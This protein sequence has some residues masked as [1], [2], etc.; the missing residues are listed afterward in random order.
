MSASA[1]ASSTEKEKRSSW[2]LAVLAR[3]LQMAVKSR[4][5]ET[6]GKKIRYDSIIFCLNC[7]A[8][9]VESGASTEALSELT[10]DGRNGSKTGSPPFLTWLTRWL[11]EETRSFRD[12]VRESSFGASAGKHAER[13]LEKNEDERLVTAGN[14]FV[15]L[16]CVMIHSTCTDAT[17]TGL[18]GGTITIKERILAELPGDTVDAKLMYVKN[19]LKAFCNFYH[20]SI[21]DLSVAV[22]AP[23]RKLIAQLQ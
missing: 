10:A 5:Q 7:L 8:N 3:V 1:D 23:V 22:V 15:L 4:N 12:A 11:V 19:T 6:E 9:C 20:Y 17:K 16:A 18:L 2:G 14:G 21:G 13:R